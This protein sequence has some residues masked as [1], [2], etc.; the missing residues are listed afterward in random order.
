MIL[1]ARK[2]QENLGKLKDFV[3]QSQGNHNG[4][5]TLMVME[6]AG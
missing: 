2:P 5:V 3:S 6:V 4:G 1:M